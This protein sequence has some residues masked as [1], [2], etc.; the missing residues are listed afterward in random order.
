MSQVSVARLNIT[1]N[2]TIFIDLVQRFNFSSANGSISFI[3]PESTENHT[4]AQILVSDENG[5]ETVTAD[6]LYYSDKVCFP[7]ARVCLFVR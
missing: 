1:E 7:Y 3:A 5:M 2:V 4:Y 6:K